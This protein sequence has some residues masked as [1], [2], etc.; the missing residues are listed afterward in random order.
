MTVAGIAEFLVDRS[1]R[2]T[3]LAVALHWTLLIDCEDPALVPRI[4]SMQSRLYS[5]LQRYNPSG[6]D[7]ITGQMRLKALLDRFG[8]EARCLQLHT[9]LYGAALVACRPVTVAELT[10]CCG[11]VVEDVRMWCSC[12]ARADSVVCHAFTCGARAD[13]AAAKQLP[14]AA[15]RDQHAAHRAWEIQRAAADKRALPGQP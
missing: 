12:D 6:H 15:G 10:P 5:Q 4:S 8:K 7:A 1:W 14:A 3:R 2:S 9:M 11:I 13:G